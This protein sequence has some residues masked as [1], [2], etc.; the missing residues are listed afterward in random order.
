ME[1]SIAISL[2]EM[3]GRSEAVP[4]AEDPRLMEIDELA[5]DRDEVV[6]KDLPVTQQD[7]LIDRELP[8]CTTI[9]LQDVNLPTE[10]PKPAAAPASPPSITAMQEESSG[11]GNQEVHKVVESGENVVGQVHEMTVTHTEELQEEPPP[12]L[13]GQIGIVGNME[14]SAEPMNEIAEVHPGG[15]LKEGQEHTQDPPHDIPD[16]PSSV[17]PDT[18][19][20]EGPIE[21]QTSEERPME[22][23]QEESRSIE[24]SNNDCPA[25][26]ASNASHVDAEVI[27]SHV[28]AEVIIPESIKLSDVTDSPLTSVPTAASEAFPISSINRNEAPNATSDQQLVAASSSIDGNSANYNFPTLQEP[29]AL[30]RSPSQA[31]SLPPAS[32]DPFNLKSGDGAFDDPAK[33]VLKTEPVDALGVDGLSHHFDVDG[34]ADFSIPESR[35]AGVILPEIDR[36]TYRYYI[37]A[38]E[39]KNTSSLK[40]TLKKP[41]GWIAPKMEVKDSAYTA[42]GRRGGVGRQVEWLTKNQT[43]SDTVDDVETSHSPSRRRRR[44]RVELDQQ[45][46]DGEQHR[47]TQGEASPSAVHSASVTSSQKGE[48]DDDDDDLTG[49]SELDDIEA[50]RKKRAERGPTRQSGRIAVKEIPSMAEDQVS[51]VVRPEESSADKLWTNSSDGQALGERN[52]Y[53]RVVTKSVCF[54]WVSRHRVFLDLCVTSKLTTR[55]GQSTQWNEARSSC[56][57]G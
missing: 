38:D 43:D 33:P 13:Q 34:L 54:S 20:K 5:D 29:A 19:L 12:A 16:V 41:E 24:L 26:P 42:R 37:R 23:F 21:E 30:K 27:M 35:F 14:T 47:E 9:P 51:R 45:D 57:A 10:I 2:A 31:G 48:Q 46:Y 6:P 52:P 15:T 8:D 32:D 44:K 18:E 22:G 4:E 49:L 7:G 53:D 56:D 3:D 25:L 1:G 36:R 50:A 11:I 55:L 40:I 39:L 28:D 17:Q